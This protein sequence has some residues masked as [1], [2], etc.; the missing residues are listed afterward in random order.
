[1]RHLSKPTELTATVTVTPAKGAPSVVQSRFYA[2]PA[3]TAPSS[4]GGSGSSS[5]GTITGVTFTGST[6]KPTIIVRGTHLGAKPPSSPAGHTSGLNGCPVVAGD[7]GYDYGTNLY[8]AV[9]AR[10][11]AG[12]RYRPELNETDCVDLIVT[13]FTPT[14]VEFHFGPFYTRYYPQFALTPGLQVQLQVN[15]ATYTTTVEYS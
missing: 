15:S 7:N 4:R 1:M 12:G 2:L 13:K 8:I 14:E 6:T 3:L 10:N 9:P 11:W 5:G